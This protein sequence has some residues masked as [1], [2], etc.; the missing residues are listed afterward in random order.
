MSSVAN[1]QIFEPSFEMFGVDVFR[2]GLGVKGASNFLFRLSVSHVGR[3]KT[4]VWLLNSLVRLAGW[5]KSEPFGSMRNNA[6]RMMFNSLHNVEMP[7][8]MSYLLFT[9]SPCQNRRITECLEIKM[10]S[11][12]TWIYCQS[13]LSFCV[14]DEQETPGKRYRGRPQASHGTSKFCQ[15]NS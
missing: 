2:D 13:N 11:A 6:E 1:Q 7:S 4:P 5:V 14:D 8:K 12:V 10:V 3:M 9:S 15:A